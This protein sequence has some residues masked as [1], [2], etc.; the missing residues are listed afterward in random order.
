MF[1]E[2]SINIED[3]IFSASTESALLSAKKISDMVKKAPSTVISGAPAPITPKALKEMEQISQLLNAHQKLST[4]FS[5]VKSSEKK[6]EAT[7][8]STVKSSE[9]KT[10]AAKKFKIPLGKTAVLL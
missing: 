1:T 6:T 4:L 5:T 3:A 9:K 10:E 2:S 8:F 7:L